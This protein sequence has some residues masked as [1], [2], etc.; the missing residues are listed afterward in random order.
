MSDNSFNRISLEWWAIYATTDEGAERDTADRPVSPWQ[1]PRRRQE[2]GPAPEPVRLLL[3]H[4]RPPRADDGAGWS[5]GR[6]QGCRPDRRPV[7]RR[8]RPHSGLPEVVA[9]VKPAGR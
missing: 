8:Y 7:R 3:L 5:Q 6:G 9:K 1:L 2:L 4:R